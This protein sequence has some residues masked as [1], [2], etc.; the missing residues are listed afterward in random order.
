MIHHRESAP[1]TGSFG[2]LNFL[3]CGFMIA[4]HKNI[5]ACSQQSTK[6]GCI[7]VNVNFRTAVIKSNGIG[8]TPT[9]SKSQAGA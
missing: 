2:H 4:Q 8:A 1:T 9:N 6:Q 7:S 3:G 5:M